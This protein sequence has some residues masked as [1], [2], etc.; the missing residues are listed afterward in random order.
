MIQKRGKAALSLGMAATLLMAS[1]CSSGGSTAGSEASGGSSGS[2]GSGKAVTLK[3]WVPIN[4]PELDAVYQ[5]IGD[6]F[7]KTHDNIKVEITTIPFADYFQ[8]LSV[9]YAGNIQP[10]VHGLGFGQL[11]STV[12]QGNYMDLNSLIQIDNWSGKDDFYPDILKAGEWNGGLYGLLIPEI[13]PLVWRKDFFKEAGL[14]PE[15]PPQ[16]YEELF[17]FA[18]KL[19]K[20]ENGKAVRSG[21]DITTSTVNNANSEQSFLSM[22]LLNGLNLYDDKGDP[23]FDSPESIQVL[24]RIMDLVK[25]KDIV[26]QTDVNVTGTLFQNNLAAMSF[27]SSYSLAQLS[28]SIGAENLGYS[29]PPKGPNGKQTSLMLG[30]FMTMAKK[31]AHPQ[32]AWEF[33]KFMF[34]PEE[35]LPFAKASGYIAPLQ[36][37]KEEFVKLDPANQVVFDA[38][39]DASSYLPSANW[40]TNVKYLRIGLEEAYFE[41]KSPEQAMKDAAASARQENAK[42]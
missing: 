5:Q 42:K 7:E 11:I 35:L 25:D 16:T 15:Q 20:K 12:D 34:S 40:S 28:K 9:A 6:D 31:T 41:K 36:S 22:L 23:T 37:L 10:D 33:L 30:T 13:R 27:A 19:A 1:A 32:E 21:L 18:K 29:L 17:E 14:D 4:T 2:G 24:E 39:N 26:F 38:M 8:K 3:V